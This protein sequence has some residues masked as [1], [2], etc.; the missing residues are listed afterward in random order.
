MRLLVSIHD[1]TPA[2]RAECETLWAMCRDQGVT[3]ALLVVPNWH[4]GSP[5]AGDPSFVDWL[6]GRVADGAE[7]FLHGERHDEVGLPRSLGDAWRAFGRTAMEGEFLTL[8]EG[9]AYERMARGAELL[10]GLGLSPIGFIPPAWLSRAGSWEAAR[11]L[12]LRVGEDHRHVILVREGQ[13]RPV[14]NLCWSGRTPVRAIVSRAVVARQARRLASGELAR[15]V[16]HPADLRHPA[17]TAGTREVLASLLARGGR[18]VSYAGLLP[19]GD[20]RVAA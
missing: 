14:P 19:E 16:F 3:P 4:G 17:T 6:H 18:A 9:P 13:W 7:L 12:D 2:L 15:V 5:L 8:D 10:R 20:A 1:V 11:R